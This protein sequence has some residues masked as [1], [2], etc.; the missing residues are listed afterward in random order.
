MT[1]A[2][3]RAK[4]EHI[5]L[6]GQW[7]E[8]DLAIVGNVVEDQPSKL[9]APAYIKFHHRGCAVHAACCYF[10]QKK[11]DLPDWLQLMA[12]KIPTKHIGDV[13]RLK[14]IS[15]GLAN[16]AS[17]TLGTIKISWIEI[18][19]AVRSSKLETIA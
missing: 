17:L 18:V 14:L 11:V 7:R 10:Y 3:L 19:A 4:V 9:Q 6:A 1:L 8:H 12:A 15:S 2:G 5:C 16:T 13:D